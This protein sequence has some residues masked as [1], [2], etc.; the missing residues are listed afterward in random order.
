MP[1]PTKNHSSRE[2]PA[3]GEQAHAA[4]GTGRPPARGP[5]APF[6][7]FDLLP[8]IVLPDENNT[9]AHL[10]KEMTGKKLLLLLFPDPRLGACK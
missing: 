7:V 2:S 1:G 8:D 9:L 5:D 4:G 6:G 3:P 10:S